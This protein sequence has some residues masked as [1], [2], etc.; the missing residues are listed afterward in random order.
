[1]LAGQDEAIRTF[2][3]ALEDGRVHH[4]WL[5]AGP[6]GVGKRR[7]ADRAA[8]ALLAGG[9][10]EADPDSPA[11]RLLAAGSHPDHRV[12][13]PP[14]EGRGA[15]TGRIVIDQVRALRPFLRG[16]PA[17]GRA[18]T[19]IV[20]PV[21]ALNPNAAN[22]LLKELEEP[23]EGT[24]F[25]LVCHAPGRLLATIR[26][27]C[28][29]LRFRRLAPVELR[30]VL[31]R[32]LPSLGADEADMLAA[33][34]D[35]APG[36]ALRIHELG[37][38]PV[39]R[40]LETARGDAAALAFARELQRREE[41]EAHALIGRLLPQRIAALA[42]AH[43]Q[44]ALADLYAEAIAIADQAAHMDRQATAHALGLRLIAARRLATGRAEA[45]S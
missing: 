30:E 6:E 36:L 10:W 44:P 34:S 38:A 33:L 8:R 42:R 41:A 20:D 1:M 45:A 4:A 27:R 5:L 40:A 9:Q 14:S 2:R 21:D 3:A 16:T 29:L 19:V 26:S 17:M 15:A 23:V 22:A 32:R 31:A 43:P 39:I 37:L 35:G 13:E 24:T 11:A 7:F 28:R 25:L 12:L 18:R